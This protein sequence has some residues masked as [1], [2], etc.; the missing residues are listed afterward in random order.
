M[1]FPLIQCSIRKWNISN[2]SLILVISDM[3]IGVYGYALSYKTAHF[4]FSC[5]PEMG[6]K[7]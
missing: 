1:Q 3:S 5:D 4:I 6:L 2:D 7:T